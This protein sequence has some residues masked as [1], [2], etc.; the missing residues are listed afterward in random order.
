MTNARESR[1]LG[2]VELE[3]STL[4]DMILNRKFLVSTHKFLAFA[5]DVEIF[6]VIVDPKRELVEFVLSTD[7]PDNTSLF[8]LGRMQEPPRIEIALQDVVTMDDTLLEWVLQNPH[9]RSKLVNLAK[10][11]LNHV[12]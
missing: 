4:A 2:I 6:H 11:I 3:F 9:T 5:D 1:R 7:N 8:R 12:M 10:R